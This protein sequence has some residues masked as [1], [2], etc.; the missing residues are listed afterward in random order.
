VERAPL[1]T[2]AGIAARRGAGDAAHWRNP[3]RFRSW[4]KSDLRRRAGCRATLRRLS[5]R[6][7]AVSLA[8][9]ASSV[10]TGRT[11]VFSRRPRLLGAHRRCP[12]RV[13]W[14]PACGRRPRVDRVVLHP[15]LGSMG[16][17]LKGCERLWRRRVPVRAGWAGQTLMAYQWAASSDR[18]VLWPPSY[19]LTSRDRAPRGP[20]PRDFVFRTCFFSATRRRIAATKRL[21]GTPSAGACIDLQHGRDDPI[22]DEGYCPATHA[23]HLWQD[24]CH[25]G[26]ATSETF[27][28]RAVGVE[29]TPV[30]T[31]SD[32]IRSR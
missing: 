4:Q 14:P 11:H 15:V 1:S 29:G 3:R 28:A 13:L 21:L 31:G 8:S 26:L 30:L 27:A 18:R 19:A 17:R 5:L 32:A 7:A 2:A 25:A 10:P 16:R 22:D 20:R 12:P 24:T 23:M 6:R 9:T